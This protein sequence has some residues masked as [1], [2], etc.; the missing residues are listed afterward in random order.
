MKT[1]NTNNN[2]P[3]G[4]K[5]GNIANARF[6][7]LLNLCVDDQLTPGEAAEL[8][9]ALLASPARRRAYEQYSRMTQACAQLF[10][11]DPARAQAPASP[12]LAR[13]LAEA[14]RKIQHAHAA[15]LRHSRTTSTDSRPRITWARGL[16][17]L[18]G[19][20]AL[21]AAAAI[22][23]ILHTRAPDAPVNNA[24]TS[25]AAGEAGNA[26]LPIGPAAQNAAPADAPRLANQEIGVPIAPT[27]T[28]SAENIQPFSPS[29]FQPFSGKRF[30]F[31]AVTTFSGDT[32]RS[33]APD[34]TAIAWTKNVQLRPIRKVSAEDAIESLRRIAKPQISST[35]L[36]SPDAPQDA[37][38]ITAFEYHR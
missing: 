17:A 16:F 29:A 30:R 12:S 23:L 24:S 15:A 13:A 22:A 10:Q 7:E 33:P 34:D 31:P 35:T 4:A 19:L 14:E 36:P 3:A 2:N 8:D 6:I 21:G 28:P 1:N 27:A 25:I 9:A 26:N 37:D 18:G 5:T 32:P 38:E 20:A 11:I